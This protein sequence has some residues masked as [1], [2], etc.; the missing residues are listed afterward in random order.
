M[1]KLAAN[2]STLFQEIPLENRPSVA[3]AAG[4]LGVEIKFFEQYPSDV[5]ID[6]LTAS[7]L[8]M[9]LFNADP[10]N[11]GAGEAGMASLPDQRQ[12]F[13][14][15]IIKDL[16][17][18]KRLGT[19]RMHV[20]CGM[21][22]EKRSKEQQY[23]TAVDAYSWAAKTAFEYGVTLV[24]E[25]L[26]PVVMP[27]YFIHSLDRAVSLVSDVASPNFK[28]LFDFFHMQFIGGDI[29][30]RLKNNIDLI[31]H[32]QI[33]A[34]PSRHEPDLG[35]LNV[36]FIFGEL[37]KIGYSGWVGCEY[38]PKTTTLAGISWADKYL[39]SSENLAPP[40]MK[41][42]VQAPVEIE[43]IPGGVLLGR[44]WNPKVQG[45]SIVTVRN[46]LVIDITSKQ[47]PLASDIC[48]MQDP[49]EFVKNASGEPI[50]ELSELLQAD[51]ENPKVFH[52]L[53]PCDL[54][55]IKA[56]GVTF[57][58]SMLERV[59]EEQSAGDVK[60]SK[61][62][63]ERVRAIVG[64][65]LHDLKAGSK[66]AQ[67]V[68]QALIEEGIWSQYLE[69]GIGPDAEVFSKAQIL[70]AVGHGAKIGLHPSSNWNN[71][72]PELVLAVSPAGK[73]VGVSLGNDVNLRDIEGRSALLLSRAKDN[74]ASCAIG[75]FI[76]LLDKEYT[77]DHLRQAQLSLVIKGLDNYLLEGSSSMNEIS[78]DPLELV[79]Q[80]IG[81]HHQYPDG[82]M[83]FLGTGFAPT[84]DRD[85]AGEGFTH[86]LG[87]MVSVASAGLGELKNMV[88]L[89]TNCPPWT[90]GVRELMKNLTRRNLL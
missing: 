19:S 68:K 32:V 53:A 1:P 33:A 26:A 90:F 73:I 28:I 9:V 84:K 34:T 5:F 11:L 62:I 49:V 52:M 61:A 77:L 27:G 67:R 35:E 39:F 17:L 48:K 83:L 21:V 14:D 31:E 72:E 10:G 40:A 18:A 23:E 42:V 46:G 25:P 16:D 59:I 37:D 4:F 80:T 6:N 71:P 47:A 60:K 69:V 74:N 8:E 75:P 78:R 58:V 76:R 88:D 54:Q 15:G 89:S 36:D 86:K 50:G 44:V 38:N 55:A 2:L 65:S 56:C 82:L 85:V 81:S 51:T 41:S 64:N 20:L 30:R 13:E 66:K 63:R 79:S 70:S 43:T 3:A 87:D 7:G 29:S 12:R 45:P 22:D 24:I 57:A